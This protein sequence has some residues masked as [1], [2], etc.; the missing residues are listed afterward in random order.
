[1][2]YKILNPSVRRGPFLA[3]IRSG[4]DFAMP[5]EGNLSGSLQLTPRV[6]LPKWTVV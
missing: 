4:D 1:M 2:N 6:R 5:A 3:R